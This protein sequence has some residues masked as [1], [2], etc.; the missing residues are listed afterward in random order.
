MSN[1][2]QKRA[3]Q[4]F[5]DIEGVDGDR[6]VE[7]KEYGSIA[8]SLPMMLQTNGLAQTLAF[9]RSKGASSQPHLALNNHLSHWLNETI[10]SRRTGDFLDWIVDQRPPIYRHA[11]NE[12]IEFSIWLRRFAEAKGWDN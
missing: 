4:A 12:A 10:G 7:N 8:R 2:D 1:L 5:N 9:L 11:G 6:N 3:R